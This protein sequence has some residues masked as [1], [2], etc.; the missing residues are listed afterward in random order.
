MMKKLFFMV[1]Y[2]SAKVMKNWE[3]GKKNVFKAVLSIMND[4]N[5]TILSIIN[6]KVVFLQAKERVKLW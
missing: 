4:K 5:N 3:N 2:F 6:D 1:I